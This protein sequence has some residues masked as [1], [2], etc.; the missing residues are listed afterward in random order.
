MVNEDIITALRNSITKG[1]S[2]QESMR[3]L[4]NTGYDKNDVQEASQYVSEGVS[5]MLK[6]NPDEYLAMP[7]QKR[8]FRT[9]RN[10]NNSSYKPQNMPKNQTRKDYQKLNNHDNTNQRDDYNNINQRDDYDSQSHMQIK[11]NKQMKKKSYLLEI[12]LAIVLL[13]LIGVLISTII[14][15]DEILRFISG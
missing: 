8:L 1:E 2:L 11:N 9:N 12:F 10:L 15:K 5:S 4:I 14:F 6:T 13:L 3:I 7:N